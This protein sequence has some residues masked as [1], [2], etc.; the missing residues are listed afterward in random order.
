[1]INAPFLLFRNYG[2]L[3][4]IGSIKRLEEFIAEIKRKIRN[5]CALSN[6]LSR[7]LF[8]EEIR[9]FPSLRKETEKLFNYSL[10]PIKNELLSVINAL[11]YRLTI[12]I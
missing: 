3:L 10:S 7:A 1:M 8:E 9:F 2:L 12:Y 5:L 11:R 4:G 6:I